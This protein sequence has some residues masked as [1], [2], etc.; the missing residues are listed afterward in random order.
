MIDWKNKSDRRSTFFDGIIH[1]NFDPSMQETL[2]EVMR[3]LVLTIIGKGNAAKFDKL[4]FEVNCDTGRVLAAATTHENMTKARIDGCS[5]RIQKLQDYW[6]ELIDSGMPEKEFENAI[7]DKVVELGQMF[8]R[9][10]SVHTEEL[11]KN[12]S[13]RGFIYTV[14][15][16]EPGVV[17]LEEHFTI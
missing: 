5:V 8:H 12:C 7:A 9:L 15:G 1:N 4:L 6:Y 13:D 11:R 17:H 3:F 14:F 2:A 10:L 16:S